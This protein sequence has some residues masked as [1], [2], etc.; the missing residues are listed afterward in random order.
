[1]Y[2]FRILCLKKK[3][4]PFKHNAICTC[5][6][7]YTANFFN[8]DLFIASIIILQKPNTTHSSLTDQKI[9]GTTERVAIKIST[10]L[11]LKQ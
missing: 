5:T 7:W 3:Y 10:Q 6:F 9:S 2:H 8:M 4:T 11:P 1:M